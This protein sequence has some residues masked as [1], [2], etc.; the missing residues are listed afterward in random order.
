MPA[1]GAKPMALL[2]FLTLERRLAQPGGTGRA[3]LG[4]V[5][6][7]RGPRLAPAGAQA[8]SRGAGRAVHADRSLIELAP[9]LG[10]RRASS[11]GRPLEQRPRPSRRLRRPPVPRGLLDPPGAAVRRVGRRARRTSLLRQ[12]QQALG[13]LAREAMGQWRW[14][15]AVE[16]ADRWLA[17]DP[18]SD[19]AAQLAV[20]ARYL[21]GNRAGALAR[22]AEF[23]DLVA[24]ETGC[25]P[26]RALQALVRR[27]EAD[28]PTP[29]SRPVTDEWYAHAPSFE[30]SLIGRDAQ[31]KT[32][33]AAWKG[34]LRG[35][36]P[37]RPGRR[38]VGRGEVPPGG[39]VP[40]VGRG[41]GRHGPAGPQLRPAGGASVR[42]GGRGAALRARRAGAGRHLARVAGRRW[43]RL[44]PELRE[45]FPA[46]PAG[47]HGAG[48]RGGGCSRAWRSSS[49]RSPPSGR[50][51]SSI[52]DLQWCDEDSCNLIRFLTRRLEHSPVLWLGA[53]D[54]GRGR[55]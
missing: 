53:A 11:S 8:P 35:A 23:R 24:R 9:P 54:A 50:W 15:D 36:G 55:A 43:R 16:L 6:R 30:A 3:P 22:Y 7:G 44:V 14:R 52:D 28:R 1:L 21:S 20:E 32:L 13:R 38:R 37:H 45:R 27:V 4:R 5:A 2:A 41:R 51:R 47:R 17:S 12:Y 29:S 26:S 48:R 18:V 33:A 31:W 49:R 19:E 10:L 42:A 34:V 46:L 39:R 25:E 40:A